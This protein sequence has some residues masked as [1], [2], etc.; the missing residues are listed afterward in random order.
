[1]G[2][3]GHCHASVTQS[4]RARRQPQAHPAL[5]HAIIG[6]VDMDGRDSRLSL[7]YVPDYSSPFSPPVFIAP[8]RVLDNTSRVV[9]KGRNTESCPEISSATGTLFHS[10]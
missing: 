1:M 5:L 3:V 2:A 9:V 10:P 4:L 6:A 7:R 8:L